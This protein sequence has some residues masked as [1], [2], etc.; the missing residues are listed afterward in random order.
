MMK[1]CALVFR[2][3]IL[4]LAFHSAE[5]QVNVLT[6][7]N[8]NARTG[9]NAN[10]TI[11]TPANVTP[12]TF[13]QLFHYDV[14]G[15]IYAQPLYVSGLA[16]AGQGKHNVVIVATEHNSVYAFDADDNTG[17][18]GGLL[19]QVNLGPSAAV[20][21]ADFG[22]RFGGFTEINSEV[23]ITGTPVIDLNSGT[24]YVDAFTHEGANYF[25]RIHALNISDG[26]ERAFSPVLVQATYPGVGVGGKNGVLVFDAKQQLQRSALTLANG[27][28][29]VAYASYSITDPY[30]GWVLGFNAGNLHL[31]SDHIFNTS[32]NGTIAQFGPNAGESGIWMAGCGLA[33]EG[34]SLYFATGTGFFNAF[35]NS[36]GTEFGDTLVKLSASGKLTVDDY[37]APFDNQFLAVND[38][39]LGSGG[40]MLL[41]DQP[42]KIPH[43][44]VCCGKPGKVY[45]VNRDQFTSDNNHVNTTDSVDMVVQSFSIAAGCYSTPTF[46]NGTLYYAVVGQPL[47]AIPM[48]KQGVF[49]TN[50][51]ISGPRNF[52]YP[53]ATPCISANKSDNAI[54]WL[55]KRDTSAVLIAYDPGDISQE[56][57]ASDQAPLGRDALPEG[58]KFAV[59][60]VANGKVYVG[61]KGGLF[62]FGLLSLGGVG[63]ANPV[64]PGS[65]AGLFFE[66]G[67]IEVG[68]S[69]LFNAK[70]T[71]RGAFTGTIAMNT[72]RS[73]FKGKF[74]ASGTATTVA[75]RKRNPPLT[76]NLQGGTNDQIIGTINGDGWSADLTANRNGS[77]SG[78]PANYTLIFPGPGNGDPQIPQGD[79][80]GAANLKKG[81]VNFTGALADGAK[82]TESAPISSDGQWPFY[83]SLPN[84]EQVLG[85]LNLANI[86]QSGSGGDISWV[87][88]PNPRTAFYPNGFST[89][90]ATIGSVYRKPGGGSP[91]PGIT[92]GVVTFSGGDL[93]SD[94]AVPI[95][96][97]GRNKVIDQGDISLTMQIN[98]L[99]GV[100]TGTSQ[101]PEG[102]KRIKFSGAV[103][104]QQNNGSGFFLGTDQSGHVSLQPN[105]AP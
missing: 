104:Q 88:S 85:W 35:K 100:F 86:V 54:L 6:W 38:L 7:H 101:N 19:W 75:R 60:T 91:I 51:V 82:L 22:N 33:A 92:D 76:L 25:H 70:V 95:T 24:L 23:G 3:S 68:R 94:V 32:P 2:C 56:L 34:T 59:P 66:P 37:F 20:P 11:L 81:M 89:D 31:P 57:Y 79:G 47:I 42:G 15:H 49:D 55:V 53:G 21:N 65:Y 102:G 69:G 78:F 80:Y 63:G 74:D 46:F 12:E 73:S 9:I 17:P 50:G 30:H 14:D 18:N 84:G 48:T 28:V 36:G 72:G 58:V 40:V 98:K 93:N 29:Y 27:F 1:L 87:K 103:L 64:A 67:G 71:K 77:S 16:I 39:D 13:G 10:E 83:V 44:L 97:S 45:V 52:L 90:L 4:G 8:N 41:P 61:T 26:S 105:P 5:A 96:I 43:L 62:V 99:S